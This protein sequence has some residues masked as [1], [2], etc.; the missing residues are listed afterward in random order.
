MNIWQYLN[1]KY[2]VFMTTEQY[3]IRF[4]KN[5]YKSIKKLEDYNLHN[6]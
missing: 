5:T 3:Y 2:I 1:V 4:P 6:T